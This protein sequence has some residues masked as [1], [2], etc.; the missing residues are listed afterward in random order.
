MV[1][2]D[3]LISRNNVH[4]LPNRKGIYVLY[5]E[6]RISLYVGQSVNV[7]NRV[8]C[9]V[10]GNSYNLSIENIERI[11]KIG[12]IFCSETDS[13]DE[14][15]Q[16]YITLLKPLINVEKVDYVKDVDIQTLKK[17]GPFNFVL[18][19]HCNKISTRGGYC[20]YHDPNKIVSPPW[21][22]R[23][24]PITTE[25][26]RLIHE[27]KYSRQPFYFYMNNVTF[28]KLVSEK[29]FAIIDYINEE[30]ILKFKKHFIIIDESKVI[31][32]ET[33]IIERQS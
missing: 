24:K 33:R 15:E 19:K 10:Y 9:H 20:Y 7:R 14:V 21:I 16:K 22:M 27:T 31:R 4:E 11:Y 26:Q 28:G 32:L 30:I 6:E 2:L 5:S 8:L 23:G 25:I 13:L 29:T 17:Q 3:L 1:E 18:C 12:I